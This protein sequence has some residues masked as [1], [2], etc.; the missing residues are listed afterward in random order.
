MRTIARA[1]CLLSLL[2]LSAT[3]FA[4]ANAPRS[5]PADARIEEYRLPP[6]LTARA[7]AYARTHHLEYLVDLVLNLVVLAL[8]I[9]LGVAARYQRLAER[10]SRRRWVQ[11]MVFAPLFLLTLAILELPTGIWSHVVERRYGLSIQGW[12]SFARDWAVGQ[13]LALLLGTFLVWL[14]YAVMRK[15]PRR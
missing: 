5:T 15:S 6:E 12:G 11:A 2:C 3:S 8:L 14:L 1:L 7:E 13:V 4:D 10:V 9:R